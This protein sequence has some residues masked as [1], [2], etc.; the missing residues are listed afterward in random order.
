MY[1]QIYRLVRTPLVLLL[2]ASMAACFVQHEEPIGA[3]E[4]VAAGALDGTWVAQPRRDGEEPGFFAVAD[5]DPKT[6][7][8]TVAEADADGNPIEEPTALLLRRSGDTLFLDAREKEGDPWRLFVIT[9]MT[10]DRIELAWVPEGD[11]FREAIAAGTFRGA[12]STSM[13]DTTPEDVLLGDL[14]PE[15]E[16]ALAKDWQNLFTEERI[17]LLRAPAN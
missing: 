13:P 6:G 8:F 17:V 3:A 2:A 14:S 15:E 7:S 12:V 4:P 10:P 5:V 9:S 11:A 16:G 1:R